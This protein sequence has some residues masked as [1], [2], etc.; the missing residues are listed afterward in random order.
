MATGRRPGCHSPFVDAPATSRTVSFRVAAAL[1]LACGALAAVW[2]YRDGRREEFWRIE[3]DFE[4][5]VTARHA[6]A[7]EVLERYE[8]ALYGLSAVFAVNHDVTRDEFSRAAQHLIARLPGAVAFEWIPIVPRSERLLVEARMRR[9]YAPRGFEVIDFDAHG[10]RH[11]AGDRPMVFPICFVE[12]L[13]GNEMILGYNVGTSP[14]APVLEK[15]RQ[16][17]QMVASSQFHLRQEEGD[18]MT[19]ILVLPLFPPR[20]VSGSATA[21]APPAPVGFL[22]CLFHVRKLLERAAK[23]TDDAVLDML[24]VDGSDADPANRVLYYHTALPARAAVSVPTETAYRARSPMI[25]D[26][27]LAVGGREWHVIY[28]PRPDWIAAQRTQTPWWRATTLLALAGLLAGF[29]SVVGRRTATIRDEVALRTAELGESRRQ[30]SNLLHSLPGMAYRARY[31]N[32]LEIVFANEGA[33]ALTGWS[34]EEFV[35]GAVDFRALIHPEDAARVREQTRALL[36]AHQDVDLEYRL[37]TRSGEEKWVLSRSRGVY[38]SAGEAEGIEG[39][40]IDITGQKRGEEDRLK[41][42]RKLLESQKLESLGLLAGGIAHDFNNLLS[43]IVGNASLARLSLAPGA[44]ADAQL[45]AI[46]NASMRAAD[47]CRQMLAYAG[48]GRFVIER[49]DL[50]ALVQ[51]LLPLL[52]VSTARAGALQLD[53]K[54]ELPGVK[55][56]ATQLR[57]IVMNLVLNAVD[58]VGGRDG[59]ID[60]RTAAVQVNRGVLQQCVTGQNLPLGIYVMLEVRDTGA[61]MPP[62]VLAKIFDPFFTTK[63]AGRGLGLAAVIGII[64]GHNGAL[65]VESAVGRGSTFRLYLPAIVGETVRIDEAATEESLPWKHSGNVLVI[66]DEEPVQRVVADLLKS[67]GFDVESASDG[68]AG[69]QAFRDDPTKWTLVILDLLLPGMDGEQTLAAVQ[70]TRPDIRVLLVSGSTDADVPTR[71]PSR[72]RVA[73]LPKPFKRE[74]FESKLKELFA[75]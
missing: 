55:A 33:Q 29:V 34:A 14:T 61:G 49:V 19:V 41:I 56:D 17:G 37:R 74:A 32:R 7:R 4:R 31:A 40:I 24:F 47:L 11:P 21:A 30:L 23:G 69:V 58:A 68:T 42:E 73:F 36:A 18:Q 38:D 63:P 8:E 64:R 3:A 2:V 39:I 1:I 71:K 10:H 54:R 6:L 51:D 52:R 45:R 44:A 25:R 12:P 15:A 16:T 9:M 60:V 20:S 26:L 62:D 67:F 53:L 35:A 28:E 65:A 50:S 5:R 72:G 27:P 66:E 75:P 59:E 13:A 57:Q 22:Q 43:A 70:A 48:K 46:E